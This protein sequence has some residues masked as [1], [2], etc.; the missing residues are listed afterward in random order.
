[1]EGLVFGRNYVFQ[2]WLGLTIKTAKN[3]KDNS[4]KQ[5]KTANSESPWTYILDGLLSEGYL[6]LRFEGL[7]F[8]RAYF[9]YFFFCGGGGGGGLLS[10]FYD[11]SSVV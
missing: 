6:H 4:I 2:N 11:S 10:E 8:G 5:L 7:I 3:T 9:F 1:M